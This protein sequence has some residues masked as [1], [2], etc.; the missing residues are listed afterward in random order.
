MLLTATYAHFKWIHRHGKSSGTSGWTFILLWLARW[1]LYPFIFKYFAD[2]LYHH[3]LYTQQHL[4]CGI[5]PFDPPHPHHLTSPPF[6]KHHL[7]SKHSDF[8]KCKK[9][10]YIT[11]T[12]RKINI[13]IILR[14]IAE[15]EE[16]LQSVILDA[17]SF[18]TATQTPKRNRGRRRRALQTCASW[19]YTHYSV[20][21]WIS[22]GDTMGINGG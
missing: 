3:L 6:N 10:R 9:F 19:N 2:L 1:C 13:L 11:L 21:I 15:R 17:I 4:G 20:I 8:K 22:D 18:T 16:T 5:K 14:K 12:H 7:T